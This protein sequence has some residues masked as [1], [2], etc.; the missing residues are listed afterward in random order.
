MDSFNVV[1][2][3]FNGDEANFNLQTTILIEMDI[4][5]DKQGSIDMTG[6]LKQKVPPLRCRK[7]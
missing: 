1:D 5:D 4:K 6:F 7:A 3:D 2:V